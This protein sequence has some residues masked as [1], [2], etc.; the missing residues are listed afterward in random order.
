MRGRSP[1]RTHAPAC[2]PAGGDGHAPASASGRRSETPHPV[3]MVVDGKVEDRDAVV[4]GD[5][6]RLAG[7]ARAARLTIERAVVGP[8][9]HERGRPIER[10]PKHLMRVPSMKRAGAATK[11]VPRRMMLSS[12]LVRTPRRPNQRPLVESLETRPRQIQLDPRRLPARRRSG[13]PG[14]RRA[15]RRYGA[16]TPQT[17][18]GGQASSSAP[19]RQQ[20][21]DAIRSPH[22]TAGRHRRTPTR[23]APFGRAWWASPGTGPPRAA[24][25]GAP[26]P[27]RPFG[28]I[29]P[30]RRRGGKATRWTHSAGTTGRL[31]HSRASKYAGDPHPDESD[32]KV[33]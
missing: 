16:P 5:P 26:K 12:D 27:T 24:P 29:R 31:P 15:P 17:Q 25:K 8:A 22:S 28:V 14:R 10:A 20:G 7:P 23:A 32:A 13:T 9:H 21:Y 33:R 18:A 2:D 11:T 1:P 3:A 30:G 19:A 6:Q 4:G